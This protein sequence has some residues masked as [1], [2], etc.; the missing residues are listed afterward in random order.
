MSFAYI[1]E[2]EVVTAG[3]ACPKLKFTI[4]ELLG[5][6]TFSHPT[7]MTKLSQ[8]LLAQHGKDSFAICPKEN[9]SVG[10]LRLV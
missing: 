4:Q 8:T 5:D 1:L 7:N 10:G 3:G 2:S 6:L 9:F